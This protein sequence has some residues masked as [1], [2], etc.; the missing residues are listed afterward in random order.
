MKHVF[1]MGFQGDVMFHKVDK[2]P[3]EAVPTSDTVI[4]HSESGH[5]HVA[6]PHPQ[7]GIEIFNLPSE[8]LESYIRV[9]EA[10]EI[11]HLK[12]GKDSHES[13]MLKSENEGGTVFRVRRGRE[14]SPKGWQ[15]MID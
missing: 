6:V 8:P 11:K 13:F 15:R 1:N 4:A 12:E 14:G 10:I 3:E 9:K 5:H 2:L 7:F